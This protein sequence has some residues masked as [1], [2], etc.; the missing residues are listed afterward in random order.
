MYYVDLLFFVGPY[1]WMAQTDVTLCFIESFCC[2]FIESIMNFSD[3]PHS[4]QAI[5]SH[6][7]T[8]SSDHN[9]QHTNDLFIF[10]C[11]HLQ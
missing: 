2:L 1:Y 9:H 11:L 6:Y 4:A 10:Y 3:F 5:S 7:C 8:N